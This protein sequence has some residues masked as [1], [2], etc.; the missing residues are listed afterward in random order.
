MEPSGPNP[1]EPIAAAASTMAV[2]TRKVDI[3]PTDDLYLAGYGVDIPRSATHGANTRL[4]ARCTILW[5]NGAPNV[6]ATADVL[7]FPRSMHQQI[8]SRVLALGVLSATSDFVLTATHTHNGPVLIDTLDPYI[9]Y[10]LGSG[11]LGVVNAYSSRLVDTMVK[12]VRDTLAAPRTTCT[13]DYQ[14]DGENFAYNREGLAYVEADVPILVARGLTGSPVAVLFGYGCHPVCA[15]AQNAFD[16]DYPGRACAVVEQQTGAFAQFLTGAA[17]DQD[18]AGANGYPFANQCGNDLGQTV[19]NAIATPG[20]AVTGPINTDYTEVTLPLD[21]T[22]SPGN[23]A[24]VRADYVARQGNTALPGYFRRHA[25]VMIGQIDAHSFATTV[26]LPLQTWNLGNDNLR[27]AIAGGEL[28]S[29]FDFY[30]R[31]NFG[32]T[33]RIWV[34]SYANEIP[35]YIP[36]DELLITGGALHYACGWDTDYPGI[37][38]GAMTI[39]AHLGHF[40]GRTPA[41][42]TANGVEQIVINTLTAML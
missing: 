13:L 9:S 37:A 36:S 8:R 39:Y 12:L 23:L 30:F 20:R 14:V 22:D 25:E 40:L 24:V 29:G 18:P 17:G 21:I 10:N 27:L 31:N 16:Y 11:Q 5:D 28:V 42:P 19:V 1:P 38:G 32:G 4:Y 2:S 35:A 26:P 3:T 33:A 34:F 6:I 41:H 15:G 7:A